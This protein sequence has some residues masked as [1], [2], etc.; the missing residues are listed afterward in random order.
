MIA[1]A[2][3][4]EVVHLAERDVDRQRVR[5]R[6]R[7]AGIGGGRIEGVHVSRDAALRVRE[8]EDRRVVGKEARRGR[9]RVA[10]VV[11][12]DEVLLQAEVPRVAPP[13]RVV[14]LVVLDQR[15]RG[16]DRV[17]GRGEPRDVRDA[18]LLVDDQVLDDVQVFGLGLRAQAR[19]VVARSAP[20]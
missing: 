4:L 16:G 8:V 13:A 12:Q 11:R 7:A 9:V 2:D 20:P 14:L 17:E 15:R 6:I 3:D 19:R 5:Q 18:L 1:E 10:R